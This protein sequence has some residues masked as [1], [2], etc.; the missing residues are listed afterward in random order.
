MRV[1]RRAPFIC[2]VLVMWPV[3]GVAG[4]AWSCD[5]GPDR[6][7]FDWRLAEWAEPMGNGL[8]LVAFRGSEGDAI[9]HVA[10]HRVVRV[11][12]GV[13]P[14]L[15]DEEAARFIQ[16]VTEGDLEPLTYLVV[17]EALTYGT[18]LDQQGLPRRSWGDPEED[19]LNGNERRGG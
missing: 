13:T 1:R 2:V 6:R 7:A 5:A 14:E 8:M 4:W 3:L 9:T 11:V 17:R 12:A 16:L 19:G 10:Y 15:P 18:D